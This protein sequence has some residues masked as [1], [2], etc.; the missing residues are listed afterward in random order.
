MIFESIKMVFKIFKTNK[1]R[2]FLTM[3]G[4]IIGV[5]SVVIILAISN[6]AKESVA[7]DLESLNNSIVNVS[8]TESERNIY[9][10][11]PDNLSD[12]FLEN[13]SIEYIAKRIEFEWK[14]LNEI[15]D[16][17]DID[18]E[19]DIYSD[20]MYETYSYTVC[21]AVSLKY[22]DI[23]SKL[24][25]K[26]LYGRMFNKIDEDNKLPV[27]IVREDVAEE[28]M[29][30]NK[31]I[32]EK[33]LINNQEVRI[34]GVM[35]NNE[36]EYDY[37]YIGDI[38]VLADYL[39]TC[40]DNINI[41]NKQY[42]VKPIS[43]NAREEAISN[44]KTVLNEYISTDDYFLDEYYISS[45]DI[46]TQI[47]DLITIVFIGIA[48]ISLLVGGIGIMNILLVSVNERIKEIGIRRAVGATKNSI[49][50]QFLIESIAI[51]IMSGIVSVILAILITNLLNQALLSY[52]LFLVVNFEI[53]FKVMLVCGA[54]GIIFGIYPSIKAS[55]LNPADALRYE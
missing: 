33:I 19:S 22:F 38:Y 46:S 51:T 32:G 18:L 6:A 8:F 54:I 28:I 23:Y 15:R 12:E 10:L 37:P 45:E 52:N 24:K 13:S 40:N 41:V 11:L 48:G 35:K 5:L 21:E 44:I 27:C 7:Q 55:K 26:L 3:I 29:G 39:E 31:C 20:D 9:S 42:I 34:I 49:M 14:E 16:V 47:L 1:L 4:M 36:S 50:L 43:I 2:T 25:D 17:A 30:S 53:V